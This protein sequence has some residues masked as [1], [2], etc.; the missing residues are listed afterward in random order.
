VSNRCI[1]IDY[2]LPVEDSTTV[3]SDIIATINSINLS[4]TELWSTIALC[5]YFT[6]L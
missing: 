3:H 2:L 4:I 5:S 6:W 1:H